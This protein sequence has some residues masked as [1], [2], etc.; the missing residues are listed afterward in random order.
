[1]AYGEA[2]SASGFS[3][4]ADAL[5]PHCPACAGVG[6]RWVPLGNGTG[7]VFLPCPTCYGVGQVPRSEPRPAAKPPRR[8]VWSAV[9]FEVTLGTV[10]LILMAAVLLGGLRYEDGESAPRVVAFADH[11]GGHQ[12][13]GVVLFGFGLWFL[14]SALKRVLDS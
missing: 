7:L 4:L 9:A 11:I 13:V 10:F 6:R 2:S 5:D 14:G 8:S 1:M 12:A 3:R